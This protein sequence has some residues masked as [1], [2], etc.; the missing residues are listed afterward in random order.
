[1]YK[2]TVFFY[3]VLRNKE[4]LWGRGLC[5]CLFANLNGSIKLLFRILSIPLKLQ[6]EMYTFKIKNSSISFEKSLDL[7]I[8]LLQFQFPFGLWKS[9]TEPLHY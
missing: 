9:C 4:V 8:I 7:E 2:N 6:R 1:M 3:T 5:K